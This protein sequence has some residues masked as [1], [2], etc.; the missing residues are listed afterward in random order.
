MPVV[1]PSWDDARSIA[2][3]AATAL[4]VESVP[5]TAAVGR[6]LATDVVSLSPLPPRDASAMDGWAVCG[7]GP[8]TVVDTVLAGHQRH[9]PLASGEA[10][11]IATGAMMPPQA[12][13]VL[14]SEHGA[15]DADGRLIGEVHEH[16][17]V[18]PAGEEAAEGEVLVPAATRLGPAHVGLAAAA[19]HDVVDVT[20]Q[21]RTRVL[22][23]GDELLHDGVA[24]EGKI[25]DS[26]GVQLPGWLERL[27]ALVT[28]VEWIDDA[29]DALV[30]AM[31]QGEDDDLIVTTGGTAAGP[32]DGV[33]AALAR[34]G[35]ELLVESVDVRP[36]SPM[37][38]GRWPGGRHLVALPGN[39]QAAVV[40]LLTLAAPLLDAHAGRPLAALETRTLG[41]PVTSRG[42]RL[43]LV[44]CSDRSGR[45]TPVDYIGSG[46]LR[47]LASADGF[48]VAPDGQG[49]AGDAVRWLPLP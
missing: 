3:G 49:T 7:P 17:D 28:A 22:I 42:T 9:Q 48:A 37:L 1:R 32:A 10:V 25:R 24:R 44:L 26:L 34:T 21:P 43:R 45:C 12:S 13:G 29:E 41:G 20:R 46:M 35:G 31:E 15:I 30:L 40:A 11:V 47:G 18:R 8:W 39:P 19:G 38:L 6:V 33:R 36:G 27:G 5:L 16:Q 4:P 14:R 23:V 2:H